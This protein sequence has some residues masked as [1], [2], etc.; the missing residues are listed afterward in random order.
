LEEQ[1]QTTPDFAPQIHISTCYLTAA[2]SPLQRDAVEIRIRDNG[3]GIPESQQN[4]LFDP[5][6]TTKPVGKGTGLGL[7]I[8][9]QIVVERHQGQLYYKSTPNDGTEFVIVI[10]VHPH[11][12]VFTLDSHSQKKSN[13]LLTAV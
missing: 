12:S 9:Y 3:I 13:V 5:F 6:F 1:V 4:Q 2:E 10:P 8:S 7:S 11:H